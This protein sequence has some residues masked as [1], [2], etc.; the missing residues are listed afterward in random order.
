V[1]PAKHYFFHRVYNV[2]EAI[3]FG[4]GRNESIRKIQEWSIDDAQRPFLGLDFGR[5][6]PWRAKHAVSLG[7]LDSCPF[8][9]GLEP[10][11]KFALPLG[12]HFVYA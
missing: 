3:D 4:F 10:G 6:F 2:V 5:S 1:W 11:R 12:L 9:L 7:H 8:W